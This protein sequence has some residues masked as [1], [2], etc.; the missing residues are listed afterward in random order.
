MASEESSK[1]KIEETIGSA[2]TAV[3][4]GIIGALKGL[5]EIEAE[6]VTLVRKTV[7]DAFKTTGGVAQE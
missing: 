5:N 3:K 7:S 4:K 2:G 1:P 6:I